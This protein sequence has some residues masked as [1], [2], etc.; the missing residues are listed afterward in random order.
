MIAGA[1]GPGAVR[2]KGRRPAR[3]AGGGGHPPHQRRRRH[4]GGELLPPSPCL[5]P[6]PWRSPPP[7]M[8]GGSLVRAGSQAM[9]AHIEDQHGRGLPPG[10]AA[11]LDAFRFPA[12]DPARCAPDEQVA[13]C[14]L[15]LR[16]PP[17]SPCARSADRRRAADLAGHAQA[18]P[19]LPVLGAL[20]DL[21]RAGGP[22]PSS[23]CAPWLT[24]GAGPTCGSAVEHPW[25]RSG[26]G[27]PPRCSPSTS[28]CCS[29]WG[30]PGQVQAPRPEAGE[31]VPLVLPDRPGGTSSPAWPGLGLAPGPSPVYDPRLVQDKIRR[32]AYQADLRLALSPRPVSTPGGGRPPAADRRGLPAV[33]PGLWQRPRPPPLRLPA[34]PPRAGGAPGHPQPP[35]GRALR[36]GPADVLNTRELA[37]LWHLPQAL[38]DVP[39]LERTTARRRL[40]LPGDVSRGCPMASPRTSGDASRWPSRT[41]SCAGTCCWWPRPAGATAPDAPRALPDDPHDPGERPPPWSWSTPTATWRRPCW[42]SS[43]GAPGG[44]RRPRP[45][46]SCAPL[47]PEPAGHRPGLEPGQGGGQRPGPLPAGVRPVLGP[48]GGRLP[49]RPAHPL[50]GQRGPARRTPGRR[51]R[52]LRRCSRCPPSSP[53]PPSGAPAAAG[54]RPPDRAWWRS[55]FDRLDRKFAVEI[56]N[57][58]QTKVSALRRPAARRGPWW[59]S[60]A[61]R[62]TPAPGSGRAPWWSSTPPGRRRR[63]HRALVGGCLINLVGLLIGEQAAWRR[64]ASRSA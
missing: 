24:T 47:R 37:G 40:P 46:G 52:Q 54:A 26:P 30:A 19:L 57:P 31:W 15:R 61:P 38:S 55:Y 27:G 64:S 34:A 45:G 20:G 22:S 35:Q 7:V 62:S 48:H 59:G 42:A 36:R 12:L 39:L 28:S 32:V 25:R 8:R 58:V 16:R 14:S 60:P 18:D 10:R 17:S 9:R 6:S 41:T 5:S 29:C 50:R 63:R 4:A 53:T 44:R 1:G 3:W 21:R 2:A 13:A 43:P 11:R 33:Q 56:I 23:S 49:L 51:E